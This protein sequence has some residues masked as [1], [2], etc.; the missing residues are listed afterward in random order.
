LSSSPG[1]SL[2]VD[3]AIERF[4]LRCGARL[5]VSRRPGAPVTALQMHIRGGHSL[6]DPGLEGTAFLA[7]GLIDQGTAKHSEE[8]IAE[9]LET[10]GGTISGESNGIAASIAS[11]HWRLLLELS[12]ELATS[13]TYPADEFR[14]QRQRLL[15][16]L[17]VERDD[18]RVQGEQLFKRLVYGRHWLGRV[19]TGSIESVRR[20]ERKHVVRFHRENWVGRRALIA[21][22]GDVDPLEV[23]SVLDRALARWTPGDDLPY[24][25]PDLPPMATRADV[26][27]AEREQVHVYLGHLGI[28]RSEPDYSALVVMDHVLG[29][30]PGF[31]NRVAM[32]LRDQLGLAYTVH[33]NIHGSAGI[34]PGTFLAYIGTSPAKVATALAGFLG[35]MRRIQ[36]EPV[37]EAELAI[38]KDYVV[39]SFALSFQRAVRRAGY[40]ISAERYQLPPDHLEQAPRQF[41][42]VTPDDVQRAARKHLHPGS[43]CVA[44][45]GPL[46]IDDL[47]RAVAQAAG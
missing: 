16:R 7:G 12:A 36:D 2:S 8:Q 9:A 26:F 30:G 31:T 4:V 32:R 11:R 33:A 20:I 15:D 17:L 6:D 37:G 28:R 21:V 19:P 44:A 41:A 23:R 43:C 29:T 5:L 18:P 42:A 25:E 14:R 39:G 34:Y 47:R 35:E 22:C 46:A 10:R 27:R 45:S 40:M 3:L 1:P 13:P 38:A 24:P